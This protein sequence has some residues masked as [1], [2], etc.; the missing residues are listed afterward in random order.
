M[1]YTCVTYGQGI[2][3]VLLPSSLQNSR[4]T[5]GQEKNHNKFAMYSDYLYIRPCL[6]AHGCARWA[7]LLVVLVVIYKLKLKIIVYGND[8]VCQ[9]LLRNV[10]NYFP[11]LVFTWGM[12]VWTSLV[13]NAFHCD[14]EPMDHVSTIFRDNEG[15]PT[16]MGDTQ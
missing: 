8:M 15:N 7:Y 10:V 14:T 2:S 4:L 3:K 12:V 16:N 5:Y 6:L 1:R 11:P 13:C 9:R